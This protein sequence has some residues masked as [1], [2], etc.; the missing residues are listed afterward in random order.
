M[1]LFKRFLSKSVKAGEEAKKAD[2]PV[3]FGYKLAWLAVRNDDPH[4]LARALDL[5]SIVC[6]NWKAGVE[7]AYE[8]QSCV[9]ITPAL[10]SWTLAA[11][12]VLHAPNDPAI[13]LRPILETLS[14]RFDEAQYF[15]SHRV[16]EMHVWARAIGGAVIRAYGYVG[17]SGKTLWDEGK[18]SEEEAR[19][20]FR[21]FDE[22][23]A[24]A[25]NP[26]YWERKDLSYPNEESVMRLADIWSIDPTVLEEKFH[27]PGLGLLGEFLSQSPT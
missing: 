10:G 2:L 16:V 20:G 22:R 7:A 24:D 9:F 26:E 25:K 4:Q 23:L 13:F 3:S 14:A 21:F 11:G 17:E 6:T 1:D 15:C 18:Q 12:S 8:S 19:L 5:R 27:E